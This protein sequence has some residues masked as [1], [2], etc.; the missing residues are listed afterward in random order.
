MRPQSRDGCF[1]E[2]PRQVLRLCRPCVDL[3]NYAQ[4]Q[5]APRSYAHLRLAHPFPSATGSCSCDGR[6]WQAMSGGGRHQAIWSSSCPGGAWRF[7]TTRHYCFKDVVPGRGSRLSLATARHDELIA[8]SCY[9]PRSVYLIT[10]RDRT[11]QEAVATRQ[12]SCCH[13]LQALGN[14]A[15][16]RFQIIHASMQRQ[17]LGLDHDI[18]DCECRASTRS[19]DIAK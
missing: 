17:A 11:R 15:A 18:V 9:W 12:S 16:T 8:A 4:V 14:R 10:D 19:V 2:T 7:S 6:P 1:T 13:Y 3:L 5:P